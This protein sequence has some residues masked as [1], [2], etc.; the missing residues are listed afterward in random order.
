M[1]IIEEAKEIR[2]VYVVTPDLHGDERGV[3]IETFRREWVPGAKEMVQGNRADRQAG[4]FVGMHYHRNQAD[5]WYV[6]IGEAFV[7]LHDLREGS[8][9][10]DETFQTRMGP[11]FG[12]PSLYIPPGV[13]HGFWS[14]TDMTITYLVDQ[15]YNPAD[16]LAVSWRD[17]G[18]A[19]EWPGSDPV[20]S[21]RDSSAPFLADIDPA[22][23]P[24]WST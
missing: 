5:F 23:Q 8:P 24:R 6:P 22:L 2:G 3:F 9:T 1:P 14:I 4:C 17:P 12:H 13:A 10:Q 16:E 21:E 20:L 7:V 18:I 11:A 19:A 15:Y